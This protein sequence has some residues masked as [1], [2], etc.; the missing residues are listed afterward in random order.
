MTEV[1]ASASSPDPVP[2]QEPAALGVTTP[3]AVVTPAKRGGL[4]EWLWRGKALREARSFRTQLPAAEREALAHALVARELADRAH[5]P[6]DPLRSGSSLGLAVSLYREAAYWALLAQD[7]A[8]QGATLATL[9]EKVPEDLLSFAAGGGEALDEVRRA[10]VQ[11]SFVETAQLPR[12]Q[13]P[14]DARVAR[15]FVEALLRRKLEPEQRVARLL[16]Q[17][18]I[19]L[20][21]SVLL[22]AALLVG[23]WLGFE[24][25]R[26]GPDLAAGKPWRASSSLFTCTPALH[27]CE[28]ANTDIF[29]HTQEEKDP[30]V[31]IDLGKQTSFN[32]LEVVNR[33]D[34]CPD[35]A[36]PLVAE[37]SGDRTKWREVSRRTE[38]FSVWNARFAPQTARYLRLRVPRRSILHLEKVTIR[39]G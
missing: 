20:S 25:L 28:S 23:G 6:V 16:W 4:V 9:F 2:A 15:D 11:R 30:W 39:N 33:A 5:D 34:C 3:P 17:R 19:R 21:A 29:F 14:R 35:R 24:R 31:E 32:R 13:L 26:L 7:S 22:L 38:T 27:R 8:Y 12:E 37:V 18:G 10:L 1:K 36:V